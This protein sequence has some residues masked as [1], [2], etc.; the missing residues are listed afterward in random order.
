MLRQA[1]EAIGIRAGGS[2]SVGQ[3]IDFAVGAGTPACFTPSIL[4]QTVS[5]AS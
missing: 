5:V 4:I 3:Q 1:E 2:L